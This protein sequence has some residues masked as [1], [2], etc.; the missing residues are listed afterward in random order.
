LVLKKINTRKSCPLNEPRQLGE[1]TK[2]SVRGQNEKNT[3]GGG[4]KKIPRK[5]RRKKGGCGK[6]KKGS[7]L[8]VGLG[9]WWDRRAPSQLRWSQNQAKRGQKG[10]A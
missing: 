7:V 3:L 9:G 1:E 5:G 10:I 2:N 8:K 4:E 6:V